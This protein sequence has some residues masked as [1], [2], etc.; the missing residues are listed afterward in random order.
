MSSYNLIPVAKCKAIFIH[1]F[2]DFMRIITEAKDNEYEIC[3][4]NDVSGNVIHSIK[5][6]CANSL[7]QINIYYCSNDKKYKKFIKAKQRYINYQI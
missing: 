3:R 5:F 1:N 6:I 4:R 2:K 7:I